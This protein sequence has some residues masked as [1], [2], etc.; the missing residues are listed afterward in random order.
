MRFLLHLTL[1]VLRRV[2]LRCLSQRQC[3]CTGPGFAVSPRQDGWGG[4]TWALGYGLEGLPWGG[5]ASGIRKVL[6]RLRWREG[7]GMKQG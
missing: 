3:P 6:A 1:R 4:G 7:S 5:L 2:R